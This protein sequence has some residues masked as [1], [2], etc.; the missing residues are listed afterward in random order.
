MAVS[1]PSPSD[2]GKTRERPEN[3]RRDGVCSCVIVTEREVRWRTEIE[4]FYINKLF[5]KVQET[6]IFLH[7][8]L[9]VVNMLRLYY[10]FQF[11]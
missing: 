6:P 1:S 3:D 11:F 2:W 5:K 4:L 9:L 10:H 8:F 7:F